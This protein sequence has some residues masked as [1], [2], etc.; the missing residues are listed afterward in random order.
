MPRETSAFT[1]PVDPAV[2]SK[3][4][5]FVRDGKRNALVISELL[6]IFVR[7]DLKQCDKRRRRFFPDIPTI[8]GIIREGK[9]DIH[10]S[11]I[12]MENTEKLLE[13]YDKDDLFF[14]PFTEDTTNEEVLEEDEEN[15]EEGACNMKWKSIPNN[16]FLFVY[17]NSDMRRLYR[18]YAV[19]AV[20][21]D[22]AYRVCKYAIPL[23]FLVVRTNINF[24]VV[25]VIMPQYE[26]TASIYEG[27]EIIKAWNID[28]NPKNAIADFAAEE[29]SALEKGFPGINVFI[30]S[31]H[32]EQAWNRWLSRKQNSSIPKDQALALLRSVAN[33]PSEEKLQQALEMLKSASFYASTPLK[34]YFEGKWEPEIRRWSLAFKPDSMPL[35]NIDNGVER[36]KEELKYRFL[37]EYRNC[38]L[39]EI[40][41]V[42]INTFLPQ[43]YDT[44]LRGN[45]RMSAKHMEYSEQI[46]SYLHERPEWFIEHMQEKLEK[47]RSD[48]TTSVE[49]IDEG[50]FLVSS[51][52]RKKYVVKFNKDRHNCSCTCFDYKRNSLLC[53]HCLIVGMKFKQYHISHIHEWLL[54]NPVFCCDKELFD[55]NNNEA[56][57]DPIDL[58]HGWDDHDAIPQENEEETQGAVVYGELKKRGS[59]RRKLINECNSH[60]RNLGSNLWM[61]PESAL[62][63]LNKD[64]LVLVEKMQNRVN[65]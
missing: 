38:P 32:R 49:I 31:F 65:P 42:L 15:D 53:E 28:I 40:I 62:L 5:E 34:N 59:K 44:Y 60:M 55:D 24:Q 58:D 8:R 29:I 45:L 20:L 64:L 36:L 21:L 7:T 4:K 30:G 12:D 43:R 16:H 18:R 10:Y 61:L 17:Q 23:Y 52:C 9:R 35:L 27:L 1:E 25:A 51:H 6:E 14:R 3:I 41:N 26:T 2:R 19:D 57:P 50:S 47:L 39:S 54:S 46:P 13:T 33:A 63:E 11:K 48:D 22:A 56:D 37:D